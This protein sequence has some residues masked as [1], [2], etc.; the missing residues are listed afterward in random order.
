MKMI[1]SGVKG[2]GKSTTIKYILEKKPDIKVIRVGDYFEKIFKEMGLKRDEGDKKIKRED[3]VKFHKRVFQEIGK[4]CKKNKDVIIDTNLFFTKP[5]GYYPGLPM[6]A[7]QELDVDMI[8]V[9]EFN[10]KFILERRQKDVKEIGR[11]RSAAMDI[12]GIEKE[13]DVQRMY[14]FACSEILSAAVK[15]LRR[16]KK[17]KYDFEHAQENAKELLELFG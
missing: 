6:F 2:S 12:E 5:E 10:P 17:E 7:L 8:V 4:E 14:A 3:Y 13:Q 16:D 15:I 11:E 1:I 9:L